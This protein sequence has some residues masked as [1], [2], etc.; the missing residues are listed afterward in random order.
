MAKEKGKIKSPTS[1]TQQ[2]S[3]GSKRAGKLI[4]AEEKED[5]RTKRKCTETGGAL[6]S[7]QQM[8]GFRNVVNFCGFADL[9]Y[10][11]SDFTW[12]NMQDGENRIQLRLDRALAIPKWIEKFVGMR[13]YH[14]VDSTFDHCALLLTAS[15]PQRLSHAK[16]FHFEA[17]WTKN[18]NCRV[19]I[20]SSSGMGV[21][22]S[23]PEGIMENLK[24]C[25]SEL[26]S[27]SSS[28]YGHIP[29][30]IQSKWNALSTLTQQDK[31]GELS[32]KI[33]ILRRES[34]ELLDNEELYWG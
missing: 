6:R 14:L 19:V 11:G 33:R 10:C 7:Q 32:S 5:I 21:N 26:S 15:P 16:S 24:L 18:E 30:K 9:G 13:V 27:W 25:A 2:P 4:F 23:K 12:C 3:V 17:L 8:D 1:E 28:V 22:T 29:K 20:E 34:N 31:N